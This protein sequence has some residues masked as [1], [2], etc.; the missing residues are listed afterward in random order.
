[1]AVAL[2]V[3]W[4]MLVI[5]DSPQFSA[6]SAKA[7]PPA[8]VGSALAIQNSAGFAITSVSIL[9]TTSWAPQL[10]PALAWVLLPGPVLGWFAL[11]PWL[12]PV[13]NPIP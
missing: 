8:F 12:R 6:M 7:C 5:A 3:V 13:P 10:G 1:M 4:G 2:L 9:L 11:R